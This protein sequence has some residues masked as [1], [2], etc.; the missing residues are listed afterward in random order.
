MQ[1]GYYIAKKLSFRQGKSFTRTI[2]YLAITAL[3]I[4][5][6]IVLIAFGILLGFKKEIR[7]KV[8]GYAGD[9]NVVAYQLTSGN[10]SALITYKAST[11]D[12]LRAIDQVKDVQPYLH[13]AGILK[14]D[15]VLE[16]LIFKGVG[17]AYNLGFYKKY[18]T[19]GSLPLY[20]DSSDS[21]D[22]L[23]SEHTASILDLD[24]GKRLDLFFVID[25]N[26]RRRKPKISGIYNTGL[27]EFDKQFA[28]CDLRML[29]RIVGTDY[30]S[31]SG[32]EISLKDFDEVDI[33]AR[34]VK[35]R[36]EYQLTALTAKENYPTLFQWLEIVDTNVLVII[37]L[38]FVVAAINIIT[39]LLILIIDRIPMIGTLK[40]LGARHSQISSIFNWQGLY[41][42]MGG[43]IAGNSIGLIFGYLQSHYKLI[44]LSADTYYMD[45][46]PF[47][48][49]WWVWLLINAG[50]LLLCFL[51]TYIPVRLINRIRPSE[52]I[53][54]E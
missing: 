4:S 24:T 45:A 10:E 32:Y 23:L 26:V 20:T 15:S 33:V 43:L 27:Q 30:S 7:E 28:I 34:E 48:L 50:A 21:Y 52:T 29:Q 38:M 36:L 22:I 11:Q 8:T 16:G 5:I 53:R 35:R 6:C 2:T 1:F 40:S 12:T 14:T 49:P 44:S 51:F 19:K 54:F 9:I 37:V 46:V 3:S 31:I 13:K 25:G 41:I 18:L 42:I 17:S 39:V 47:Y